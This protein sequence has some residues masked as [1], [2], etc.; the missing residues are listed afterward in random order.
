MTDTSRYVC[1]LVKIERACISFSLILL[2][3]LILLELI[4]GI[5]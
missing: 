2:C 4:S 1:A 3:A 5:Y